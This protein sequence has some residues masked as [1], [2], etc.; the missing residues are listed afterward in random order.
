MNPLAGIALKVVST[1]FFT[2]MATLIKLVSERFPVGEIA[3]ARSF[4]G[5]IPVLVWAAWRGQ[6]PGVFL[7]R[8][9]RGHLLRVT[10]GTASMF[11]GF[12]ALR[13]LPIA[14][15][16][17]IGY[18]APLFT[19]AFAA[20]LLRE[21]VRL[22]R[23]SA[24]VVGLIGVVIILSEY[25]SPT[26]AAGSLIGAGL[27]LSSAVFAAYAAIQISFLSRTE[28]AGTIV[29]Y[30][31]SFA[32]LVALCTLPF[33]WVVPTPL[34]AL[35]L[36]GMGIFGG[37]GQV[38]MTTSYRY[39]DASVLAPFDYTSMLWAVL[40]SLIVFSTVPTPVVLIGSAVIIGAG[41][42][43]IWRERQLGLIRNRIKQAQPPAPPAA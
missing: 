42:F 28:P 4:F 40:A 35:M 32:A 33:G 31:S 29:V 26:V 6:F 8:N 21:T 30:F 25:L 3:F 16:T 10:V 13:F 12:S 17:A 34:E 18:A 19:V 37:I 39:A 9:P 2:G 7:T 43:V 22:Y 36:V 15:A 1:A 20:L 11:L 14:D 27:Q 38:L 5:L 23:W 41:L 24:V